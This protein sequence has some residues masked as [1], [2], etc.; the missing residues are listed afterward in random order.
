MVQANRANRNTKIQTPLSC[1][2]QP[3]DRGSMH[4]SR[5]AG[6]GLGCALAIG[7]A[8]ATQGARRLGGRVRRCAPS[9]GDQQ[10]AAGATLTRSADRSSPN[11]GKPGGASEP[12][13]P[14]QR[15]ASS[16]TTR[17]DFW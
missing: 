17:K 5:A 13:R 16:S 8:R 6:G 14:S 10:T 2:G 12:P 11:P 3:E 7:P 15:P 9:T 1:P 4:P